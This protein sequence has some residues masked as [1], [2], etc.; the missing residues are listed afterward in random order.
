MF[1]ATIRRC[2]Q[3][4]PKLPPAAL[5]ARTASAP[6]AVRMRRD[7]KRGKPLPAGTSDASPSGLTPTEDSRYTRLHALRRLQQK[8]GGAFITRQEWIDKINERRSRVRGLIHHKR[9]D[10]TTDVEL[11]GVPIYLPN[12]VFKFVS[13]NT[14]PGEPY[15]PYEA[16]FYVPLN[17][18]KA[19][20]RSY[21]LS[22]YGVQTTYI[23]TEVIRRA[24]K[25]PNKVR[26]AKRNPS[27]NM[28]APRTRKRAVVGLVE[29]FYYPHRVEEMTAEEKKAFND[30]LNVDYSKDFANLS[31]EAMQYF[32]RMPG[33]RKMKRAQFER[34]YD[35]IIERGSIDSPNNRMRILQNVWKKRAERDANVEVLASTFENVRLEA[36]ERQP[37]KKGKRS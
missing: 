2:S 33:A 21:L 27:S 9:E 18:T 8:P 20:I 16:T 6:T 35:E 5:A 26:A 15:N 25:H 1:S 19:D 31:R 34:M 30:M 13:N 7:K 28:H 23:R 4:P 14:P 3:Q 22:M 12:I 37:K 11:V 32:G 29:P 10:G 24:W 36:A 17:I